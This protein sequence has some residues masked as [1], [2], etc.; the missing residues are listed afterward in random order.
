MKPMKEEVREVKSESP[1]NDS[2]PIVITSGIDAYIHERVKSQPQTLEEVQIKSDREFSEAGHALK[3]PVEVEKYQDKYGFRWLNK[4]KQA[5]DRALDV[6]GWTLVH[7]VF[8]NE[9]P[10]HLFSANGV[11]ERGDAILAFMPLK[12]A[13]ELR[14]KPG[15]LSRERVRNLPVQDLKKWKDRGEKYFKP[16]LGSAESDS[17]TEYAKGNKGMV[18][19]P[20]AIAIEE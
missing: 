7:R 1:K 11:I 2:K 16:D 14:K 18:V 13:I 5:L 15:E 3:L 4:R 20:D 12:R 8:F 19:Q 17:D 9:L 6:V 10:E